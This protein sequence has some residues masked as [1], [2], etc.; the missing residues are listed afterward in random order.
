MLMLVV[1]V[2]TTSNIA[3]FCALP[4]AVGVAKELH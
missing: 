2:F 4:P 1:D 3:P